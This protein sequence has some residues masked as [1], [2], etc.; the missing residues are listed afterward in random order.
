[1]NTEHTN[2]SLPKEKIEFSDET[3]QSLKELGAI[4]LRI[5]N[6]L[7]SEGYV[8]KDGRIYKDG[9]DVTKGSRS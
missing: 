9:V 4:L 3:I 8:I 5:H 2:P 7:I 1:M 6:R